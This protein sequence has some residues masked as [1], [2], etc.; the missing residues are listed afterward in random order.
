MRGIVDER[1]AYTRALLSGNRDKLDKL[2]ALLLDEESVDAERVRAEL[3]LPPA[4]SGSAGAPVGR[5]PDSP[6]PQ[7]AAAYTRYPRAP[8]TK[9]R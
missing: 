9:P 7:R 2:A 6:P 4:P 3:G 1:L 5:R 8:A